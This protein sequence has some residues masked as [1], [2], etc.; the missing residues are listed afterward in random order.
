MK[1]QFRLLDSDQQNQLGNKLQAL[2]DRITQLDEVSEEF[3][4][5]TINRQK[6]DDLSNNFAS[7]KEIEQ[8]IHS[9]IDKLSM[10]KNSHED[11]AFIFVKLK[12]LLEQQIDI[13]DSIKDNEEVLDKVKENMKTNL[14]LMKK[15]LAEI[16]GRF[17]KIKEKKKV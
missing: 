15:N 13:S 8:L 2:N 1:K 10:L 6:I 12:D 7:A 4:H 3:Y 14:E 5:N 16:R 17:Q 9:T 11:S